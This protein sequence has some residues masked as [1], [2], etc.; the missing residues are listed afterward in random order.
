MTSNS[1]EQLIEDMKKLINT[2]IDNQTS[3]DDKEIKWMYDHCQN[4]A[5]KPIIRKMTVLMLHVLESIDAHENI[6]CKVISEETNILKGTVSKIAKK[7]LDLGLVTYEYQE[8]NKKEKLY[9]STKLGSEM[10]ILHMNMHKVYHKALIS[11]LSSFSNE[12]FDTTSK[13]IKAFLDFDIKK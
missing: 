6:N 11:H 5:L 10:S 7:L 8:N 2:L 3:S 12:D 9:K 13:M 4:D 1:K